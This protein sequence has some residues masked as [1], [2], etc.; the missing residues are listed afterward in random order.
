ME[1]PSNKSIAL[2]IG[3][4]AIKN[5]WNPIL[6]ALQPS[7]FQRQISIEAANSHLARLVYLLRWAHTT[8]TN[9][10]DY[11]LSDY[12]SL[13]EF[14][15]LSICREIK[16][17]QE[18]FEITVQ[19]QFIDI[20]N[21]IILSNFKRLMIVSTNWDTVFEDSLNNLPLIQHLF[22]S[23]LIALHLHGVYLDP[24]TLYLPT[25]VCA[26][27][28]R[29]KDEENILGALHLAII[30]QIA[31]AETLIIYGLSVSPLDAELIQT[32]A[33]G[34]DNPNIELIIIIDP[35]YKIVIDRINILLPYPNKIIVK[36]YDPTI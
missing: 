9:E 33:V 34:L 3:A 13:L 29:A 20:I 6:N 5:G 24:K 16:K 32:L 7:Y 12:L 10:D 21:K 25:E 19:D 26:E 17:A 30:D 22:E 1:I 36:G 35:N 27:P 4:G 14:T 23:K 31:K 8:K 28:Y 15:K 18:N 2:L 11:G